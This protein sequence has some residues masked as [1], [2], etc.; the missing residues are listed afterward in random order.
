MKK[1]RIMIDDIPTIIWGEKSSKIFIAMHGNMSNKEDEV[2]KIF[3]DIVVSLGYQLL[4]FDLPEHGDRK[5]NHAYLCNA[6][7]CISDLKI[8][9][10]YILGSYD[11]INIWA[12]SMSAY[13]SLIGLR[14]KKIKQAIF[15]SPVIDM[16]ELIKKMM[17]WANVSKEKLQEEKVIYTS[18]GTVL[19]WDY[20]SFVENNTVNKWEVETTIICGDE[21]DM[22]DHA[23]LLN[24]VD[25]CGCNLYT[26]EKGEHFFH[27]KPQLD[28]YQK[29][30]EEIF[31]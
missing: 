8:V 27:T 24:F 18:F 10:E 4:S 2:I 28:F 11:E 15:L 22:Q 30:L 12:C 31:L 21:D 19:Y 13:F 26:L 6:Q 25:K 16:F 23:S 20:Y 29:C 7:N 17:S 14:D 5:D 3:A 9:Y 1:E